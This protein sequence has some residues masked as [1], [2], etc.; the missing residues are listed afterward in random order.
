MVLAYADIRA[1]MKLGAALAHDNAPS[2]HDLPAEPFHTEPLTRAVAAVT[3][4]AARFFMRHGL[5]PIIY[6][7]KTIPRVR[8]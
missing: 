8:R 7:T 5:T 2:G 3:R 6:V 4:R 1:R